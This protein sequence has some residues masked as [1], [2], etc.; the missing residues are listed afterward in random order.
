[1]LF[2]RI[3]GLCITTLCLVVGTVTVRA[4][5]VRQGPFVTEQ[6][7]LRIDINLDT[8]RKDVLTP[9]AENWRIADGPNASFTSGDLTIILRR[10]GTVGSGLTTDWWKAGYDSGV[11][12]MASDG[13]FITGGER[14]GQMEIVIHGLTPG[15]HSIVTY[16]NSLRE[17]TVSRYNVLVNGALR[18]QGVRPSVRATSDYDMGSAYTELEAQEGK[19][20]VLTLQPDGSG[21]WDNVILNGIEI[22]ASDP[23]RKALQPSPAN[24]DEHAPETPVLSWAPTP[25]ATAYQVYLGTDPAAVAHATPQSR[26]Y[27]GQQTTPRFATA[28]LN[29]HSPYYWRVDT[30]GPD[31][32]VTHGDLWNFRVRHLAFPGAEGYGRFARGGRG[33]RVIE[34]TNLNDSGPGSLRAAVEV[35]GPRTV[36]FRVGGTIT[37]KERLVIR[38]PYLTVAGQ[39]APGDGIC[40]RGAT[41]GNLGSHDTIIRYVRV[42]VGDES[43]KTYDGMGFASSDHCIIDH[44]SISWTIDEAVSSRGAR[45]VTFQR[46]MIAEALNM[47][48]HEKYT[49]TG[50][51][52]SFAGSISGNIGSFH[53]NLVA[54]CA[55][56]NW[57]LAGGLTPGGKFAG[58]LDVRNNVVYNWQHRTNDGGVKALNLIGNYYIPGPATRVFHLLK[59]DIGTPGDPQQYYVQGNTMESRPQYDADNWE[60]GGVVFDA[61]LS[62][63]ILSQVK[64]I[65]PFCMP[66]MTAQ[67]A[68]DAYQSVLADVGANYPHYDAV[69]TRVL[70]DVRKR[71]FTY[72]G[73]KTGIPG[74]VDSQKDSGGWPELKNGTPPPDSDQ[75]GIP[76]TW[77]KTHRLNSNNPA[78]AQEDSG[79]GY[80]H[81]EVYLNSLVSHST[82]AGR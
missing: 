35:E 43:G 67:T 57:S 12:Q 1:M 15:K 74:I 22:D 50:K 7:P 73:S 30:V 39:T 26:E 33:G 61:G 60:N 76:D 71:G 16:H 52:H 2:H 53:H 45:N 19:D 8:D 72:K 77:E 48:V 24:W 65:Q 46:C 42:R 79:D 34:V 47:S 55:G 3:A 13:V 70:D 49:G 29:T 9:H 20:I 78:D 63:S 81:L 27:R 36:V 40:I 4:I 41:F 75:D 6:T 25:S 69:D 18:V 17:G 58:Y 38:N 80:T 32:Q 56:R 10:A 28:D 66:E 68:V 14:G 5:T 23:A 37:L 62:P 21:Q 31:G 59:P 64:L 44:C 11:A 82:M 51:G 54:H